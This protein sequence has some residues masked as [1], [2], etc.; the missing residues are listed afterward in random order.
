MKAAIAQCPMISEAETQPRQEATP[1]S[2]PAI[3]AKSNAQAI[4]YA[5]KSIVIVSGI[6]MMY[7]LI[8]HGRIFQ[9]YLQ[10]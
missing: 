7:F 1:V 6:S 3:S 5:A 2:Q 9:N 4:A 10:W 8:N